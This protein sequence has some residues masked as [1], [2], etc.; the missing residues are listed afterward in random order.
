MP[1][2]KSEDADILICQAISA[3]DVETALMIRSVTGKESS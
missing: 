1:A 2:R 3:G